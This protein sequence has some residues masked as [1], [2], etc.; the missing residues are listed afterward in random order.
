MLIICSQQWFILIFQSF[1][2][3]TGVDFR[4]R[5]NAASI[6]LPIQRKW[7]AVLQLAFRQTYDVM[8]FVSIHRLSRIKVK[9][10]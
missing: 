1:H 8:K 10:K 3:K 4:L 5:K 9:Y 7:Y 6:N 2:R